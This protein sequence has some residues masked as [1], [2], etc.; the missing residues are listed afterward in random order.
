MNNRTI[1]LSEIEKELL[2]SNIDSITNVV[3]VSKLLNKIFYNDLFEV[4]ELLPK[5]F[6]DLLI[7][8]P[9][10]N[11]TKQ[12]ADKKFYKMLKSEYKEW[13]EGWFYKLQPLLKPNSSIYI[14]CDWTISSIVEE[15]LEKFSIIRNRITWEREKGRGALTNWKNCSEDIWFATK[16]NNY[17]FNVN[18]VKLKKKVIA[19]YKNENGIAKDWEEIEDGKFRLTFP[20]NLWTDITIPFWSMPENTQHPTQKPEKLLAKLILA[21]SN[22]NDII[23]DP[24]MG[25]GTTCVTAKKLKRQFVGIEQELEY[26]LLAQHRLNLADTNVQIQGYENGIFYERNSK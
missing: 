14:C 16:S 18:N 17:T 13:F 22:E 6:V 12:Y 19:P 24:F 9:P 1:V 3:E 7:I 23:F 5:E 10:Y 20:S 4:L 11:L 25:S 8:D 21:S 15:V 26:Y 2:K